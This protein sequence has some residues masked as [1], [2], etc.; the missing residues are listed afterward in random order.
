MRNDSGFYQALNHDAELTHFIQPDVVVG[1]RHAA[2]ATRVAMS[3]GPLSLE[4]DPPHRHTLIEAKALAI[5]EVLVPRFIA[6]AW[7]LQIGEPAL[8]AS[9]SRNFPHEITSLV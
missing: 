7:R 2:S 1:W 8:W 4:V 5:S 6:E 9:Y 3:D